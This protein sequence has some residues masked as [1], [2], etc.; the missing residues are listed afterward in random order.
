[1]EFSENGREGDGFVWED[2]M[3]MI[4]GEFSGRNVDWDEKSFP[5]YLKRTVPTLIKSQKTLQFDEN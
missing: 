1:M 2:V 3:G 4:T 5:F